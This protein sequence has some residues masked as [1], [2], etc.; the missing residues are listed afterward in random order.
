VK[1]SRHVKVDGLG[2]QIPIV[3]S[4]DGGDTYPGRESSKS[5]IWS[6]QLDQVSDGETTSRLALGNNVP[7]RRSHDRIAEMVAAAAEGGSAWRGAPFI[8]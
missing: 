4:D 8:G 2:I 5:W 3:G 1:I 6:L 7:S